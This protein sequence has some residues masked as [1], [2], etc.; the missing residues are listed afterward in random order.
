MRFVL[1]ALVVIWLVEST[2]LLLF[3]IHKNSKKTLFKKELI[4]IAIAFLSFALAYILWLCKYIFEISYEFNSAH[5]KEHEGNSYNYLDQ[6]FNLCLSGFLF[7][8]M[9]ILMLFFIHFRS[10]ASIGRLFT[11]GVNNNLS[12]KS[13]EVTND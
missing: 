1:L 2:V 13:S 3:Q 9:P 11:V 5:H 6:I 8:I 10:Y 4:N 12:E 7:S